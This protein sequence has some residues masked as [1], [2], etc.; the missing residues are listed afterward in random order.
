MKTRSA[1]G[2]IA[3]GLMTIMLLATVASIAPVSMADGTVPPRQPV[4]T[5]LQVQDAVIKGLDWFSK[6]QAP[7]GSWGLSAGVTGLVV[8][9]FVG[10]GY[11]YTNATVQRA[12]E[13]MR[14]YYNP[15]EGRLADAFLNYETAISIVAMSG[16]GDPQDADKIPK[17]VDF[18]QHL[19]FS[20][21][22][23][24]DMTEDSYFGGWPNYA[25]IPD[26]SNSQFALMGLIS[27]E[28]MRDDI[29]IPQDVWD[30]ATT[31]QHHCQNYPD[32]NPL[33]WAHNTSLPSHG[34]GGFVYNPL[35]SRTGLGEDK[36]ESYGSITAAGYYSY[37]VSG[38]DDR[39]PEVAAAREWLESEYNLEVNPRMEGKGRFYYLWTQ[40][41]ALAMGAQDWVV[42][43]SGKL[44]DWRSEVAHLF[45]DLQNPDGGWP[46]NPNSDWREGE[47]VLVGMYAI[48]S[49]EQAYLMVPEP[50]LTIQID[51]ASDVK[52]IDLL[53]NTLKPDTTRGL[54]V[55]GDSLTCTDPELFSKLWVSV[56]NG[57]QDATITV[58]GT[59]A[60]DRTSSITRSLGPGASS[61]FVATGGFAGPFGIHVMVLDDAPVMTVEKRTVE[62]VPGETKVPD[63][64]VSETSGNGPIVRTMLITDTGEGVVADVDV[65][66][67]D[68]PS[69][70]TG[71]M[72][73]TIS[74]AEDVKVGKEWSLVF[75]SSTTPPVAIPVRAAQEEQQATGATLW[76]LLIIVILVVLII[77]FLLLPQVARGKGESPEPLGQEEGEESVPEPPTDTGPST[78]EDG[79][80]AG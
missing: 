59:W 5:R 34:D 57:G 19:Q 68:V 16:A 49:L 42:D 13:F 30:G 10:A 21:D 55:N 62:L 60:G 67:I 80:K 4:V 66:G 1:N 41:R 23:L 58:T 28:L 70:S 40:T 15:V 43:S 47:R 54:T 24:Y 27:A 45:I 17:M 64:H 2:Y 38:C 14:I 46:V 29:T 37:L 9:C 73:L 50:E 63:F 52:F 31:F 76:Y 36:F 65:Q 56:P 6:T 53:G 39:Q 32:V 61:A 69:G 74:L 77:F 71:D 44:H 72:E 7:D 25:G 20:E 11:D 3:L 26:I 33:P 48:L 18:M 79:D 8:M 12:L 22:S 35:R 78:V 75:T 51:G